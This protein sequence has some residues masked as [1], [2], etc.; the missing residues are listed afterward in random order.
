MCHI[1]RLIAVQ[2]HALTS[3][4][5]YSGETKLVA[6][7]SHSTA[8]HLFYF[9]PFFTSFFLF[10]LV[11]IITLEEQSWWFTACTQLCVCFLSFVCF[12]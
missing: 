1:T 8:S 2:V 10:F 7:S 4:N 5:Y 3:G 9:T 12:L 6:Y 11:V